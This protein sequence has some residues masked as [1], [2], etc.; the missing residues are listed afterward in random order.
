M[1]YLISG[2]PV[3]FELR[4]SREI[5]VACGEIFPPLVAYAVACNETIIGEINGKWDAATVVSSD[6]G[7]GL[8]QLT[9]SWPD[10][11]EDPYANARYAINNFLVPAMRQWRE[12]AP[13]IMGDDLVRC[14]AATFNA[15]FG[16]AWRGHTKGDVDRFTTDNYGQRALVI[17]QSLLDNGRI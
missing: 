17:Y 15:G 16:G 10:D 8:F 9:S 6:S 13:E 11:W 4:Y 3:P 14:I 1:I 5:T 7:H 12:N 2:K